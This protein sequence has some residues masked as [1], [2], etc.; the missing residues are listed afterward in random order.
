MAVAQYHASHIPLNQFVFKTIPV[1]WISEC[2]E[3]CLELV[4]PLSFLLYNL[5][6]SCIL[7]KL[8][9]EQLGALLFC[10][11]FVRANVLSTATVPIIRCSIS[12]STVGC[13]ETYLGDS[14]PQKDCGHWWFFFIEIMFVAELERF[15]WRRREW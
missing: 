2:F 11:L 1:L 7:M 13:L 12:S 8:A 10:L 3:G 15:T 5:T 14:Q 4:S 6:F 9:F